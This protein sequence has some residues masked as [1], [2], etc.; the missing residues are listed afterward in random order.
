MTDRTV[1]ATPLAALDCYV[2]AGTDIDS[3]DDGSVVTTYARLAGL[4]RDGLI[5]SASRYDDSRLASLTDRAGYASTVD[6]PADYAR[7]VLRGIAAAR[8]GY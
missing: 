5:G 6:V 2:G 3:L 8:P 1:F 4:A 7:D